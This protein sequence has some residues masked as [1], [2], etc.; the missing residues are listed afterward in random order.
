VIVDGPAGLDE[1]TGALLLVAD[2]ALI[3][4][5]PSLLDVRAA[6]LAVKLLESAQLIR[7]SKPSALFVCNKV[8][9]QTRLS[10]DLLDVS[11]TFGIPVAKSPLHFRQVYADAVSQHSAVSRMGYRGKEATSELSDLFQEVLHGTTSN[12]GR[13]NGSSTNAPAGSISP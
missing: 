11:G 12:N 7:D 3:P 6:S 9:L 13:L 1:I 2:L 5:G 10:R 4:C 8:Q